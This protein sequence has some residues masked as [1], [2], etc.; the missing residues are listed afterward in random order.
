MRRD[1]MLVGN[2]HRMRALPTIEQ[3]S[4]GLGKIALADFDVVTAIGERNGNDR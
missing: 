1:D 2:H 3:K 4:P